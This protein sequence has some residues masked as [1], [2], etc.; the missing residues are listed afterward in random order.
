MLD[1]DEILAGPLFLAPELPPVPQEAR[2]APMLVKGALFPEDKDARTSPN[3]KGHFPL[4]S[5]FSIRCMRFQA[6]P[7]K[8]GKSW[9]CCLL[10]NLQLL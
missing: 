6:G 8:W 1:L 7:K 5:V 2:E 4:T 10:T 9:F 3:K